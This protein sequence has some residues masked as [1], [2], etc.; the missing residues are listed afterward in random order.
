MTE[1][2]LKAGG[3]FEFVN[4]NNKATVFFGKDFHGNDTYKLVFNG[5]ITKNV[6]SYR[7]VKKDVEDL[8]K[9]Y[10]LK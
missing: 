1:K 4:Q 7:I 5:K 3:T 6:K 8:K 10:N 2:D 9:E